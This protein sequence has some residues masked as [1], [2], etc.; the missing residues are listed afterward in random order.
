MA[1]INFGTTVA[2]NAMLQHRGV[3]TAMLTTRGFR[4][5][6]ELR[7]GYKEVLFDIRLPPPQPIVPR[8]WRLVDYRADRRCW[9]NRL[10][11]LEEQEVR[12]GCGNDQGRRDS[13]PSRLFPEFLS[14]PDFTKGERAKSCGSVSRPRYP[15]LL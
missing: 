12:I 10:T 4:D 14:Q 2:T 7:R 11:A 8:A 6:V 1:V 13:G 9:R 15:S 5:I 3:P